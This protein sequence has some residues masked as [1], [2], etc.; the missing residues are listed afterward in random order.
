M[1]RVRFNEE[2]QTYRPIMQGDTYCIMNG[3]PMHGVMKGRLSSK[4]DVQQNA[5]AV[6]TSCVTIGL[7]EKSLTVRPN[8]ENDKSVW[9]APMLRGNPLTQTLLFLL[10]KIENNVYLQ[11]KKKKKRVF[12]KKKMKTWLC[13]YKNKKRL[14]TFVSLFSPPIFAFLECDGSTG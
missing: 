13:I 7:C 2:T 8:V 14:F 5:N 10:L 6:V 11:K 12:Y 4:E 9:N 1:K 3:R